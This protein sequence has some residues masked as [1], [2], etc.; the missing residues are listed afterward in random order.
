MIGTGSAADPIRPFGVPS[1]AQMRQVRTPGEAPELPVILS[2]R[3]QLAPDKKT[4]I[5]EIVGRDAEALAE[6]R[7]AK[8]SDVKVFELGK[9]SK[10]E[11]EA[12]FKKYK[13]D[14]KAD[15]FEE[16]A[17]APKVGGAK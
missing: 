2:Y 5:L 7:N 3:Y 9:N 4:A 8:R 14:F 11:I 1:P 10:D 6:L 15:D 13:P 17:D 12:E 16:K